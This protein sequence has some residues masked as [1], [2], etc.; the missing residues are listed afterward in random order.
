MKPVMPS[1]RA[2]GAA[3]VPCRHCEARSDSYG[4]HCEEQSDAA[5][6]AFAV[7]AHSQPAKLRCRAPWI[8]TA[9]RASR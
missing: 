5:I 3:L 4:R 8:A 7:P 2:N 6:H 1:P 9:L